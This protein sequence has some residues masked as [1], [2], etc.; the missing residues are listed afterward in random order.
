MLLYPIFQRT[1]EQEHSDN[2]E[3][4]AILLIDKM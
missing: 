2:L 1:I 4:C 3:Y